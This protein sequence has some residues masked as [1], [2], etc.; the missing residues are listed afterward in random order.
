MKQRGHQIRSGYP[1][2]DSTSQVHQ[3][4][5]HVSHKQVTN[6]HLYVWLWSTL[7]VICIAGSGRQS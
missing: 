3:G 1:V 7:L 6:V 4:L 5:G 2:M